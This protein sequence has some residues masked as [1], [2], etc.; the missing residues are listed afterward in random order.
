MVVFLWDSATDRLMYASVQTLERSWDSIEGKARMGC[1]L[2]AVIEEAFERPEP[3]NRTPFERAVKQR[4]QL[5]LLLQRAVAC[6]L[7][8]NFQKNCASTSLDFSKQH[9]II[10][11]VGQY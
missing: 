7:D 10:S 6:P 8:D 2:R 9:L 3:I 1:G 5:R 4:T 11:L